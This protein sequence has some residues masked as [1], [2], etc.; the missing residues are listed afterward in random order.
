MASTTYLTVPNGVLRHQS[1]RQYTANAQGVTTVPYPDDAPVGGV[2]LATATTGQ[3]KFVRLFRTGSTADRPQL[4]PPFG[5]AFYDLSLT[6]FVF[7]VGRLL[8]ATGYVD[9]SGTAS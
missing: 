9:Q 6:K 3:P 1:G 4:D 5:S 8:S 7:F 2:D